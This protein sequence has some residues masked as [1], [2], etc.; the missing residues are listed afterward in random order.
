[1]LIVYIIYKQR[2][3]QRKIGLIF[4]LQLYKELIPIVKDKMI[5]HD[6]N[7]KPM[8]Y[9]I[10]SGRKLLKTDTLMNFTR[11][12]QHK[13]GYARKK[14]TKKTQK[15]QYDDDDNHHVQTNKIGY[16]GIILYGKGGSVHFSKV[17]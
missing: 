3:K 17:L 14:K 6:E 8:G 4:K 10:K 5:Y 12:G 2:N 1:M 15:V 13:E 11:Q 16:R 7:K 9:S